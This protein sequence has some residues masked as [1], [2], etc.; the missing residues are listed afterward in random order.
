MAG[1]SRTAATVQTI[2]IAFALLGLVGCGGGAGGGG[3]EANPVAASSGDSA[4]SAAVDPYIVGAV[5]EEISAD[6][7]TVLQ[8]QST[9][10]DE[11]GRFE[12]PEPLTPGSIVQ[13]KS[14]ARGLHVGTPF[15][16]LL[17]RKVGGADPGSGV[18]H[19][20][21]QAW[22]DAKSQDFHGTSTL[23]CSTCHDLA[24]DCKQC[25]FGW[26]GQKAPPASVWSHDD[27]SH[28]D[29]ALVDGMTVCNNCHERGR[30]YGNGPTACHDCHVSANHPGGQAF[31]TKGSVEFHGDAYHADSD[32]CASCH[33]VDFSGG[34]GGLDCAGCHFGAT[35]AREPSASSWS[36]G[37]VPHND[38]ILADAGRVCNSCHY[39]N[40]AYGTGPDPCH[41]CHTDASHPNGQDWLDSSVAGYHGDEAAADVESCAP[42]HGA[43]FRGGASG[44]DCHTCH[45]GPAGAVEP[46]T[47]DGQ[48]AVEVRVAAGSDGAEE[49]PSGL[50]MLTST[51]LDLTTDR[52]DQTVGVRFYCVDVPN[53]ASI[54]TAY[55][56]FQV[57]ETGSGAA[58]FT[59]RGEAADYAAPFTAATY[60][61]SSRLTTAAA[62]SWSPEPWTKAG[63]AGARQRTPEL[64]PIIQEIL[65]RPGWAEGNSLVILVTGTGDRV[66]ESHNGEATAAALLHIENNI[67]HGAIPHSAQ[68]MTDAAAV[69][70]ACHDQRRLYGNGPAACHDCHLGSDHP[71]GPDF[72]DVTSAE[73]HGQDFYADNDA[74]AACHGSDF[75]GGSSAVDC[76]NC[77][78][79]P[80]GAKT[81]PGSS[82]IHAEQPHDDPAL[83]DAAAVCN[84]CHDQLRA[85]GLGPEACHDCHGTSTHAVP[86]TRHESTS[87][88]P[89]D[90]AVCHGVDLKGDQCPACVTCHTAGSPIALTNCTS[91]HDNPPSGSAE[92]NR[93]G[94]HDVHVPLVAGS[95]DA[96]HEGAGTQAGSHFDQ[97][98]DVSMSSAYD[99]QGGTAAYHPSGRTCSNVSCHGGETAPSWQNGSID[100]NRR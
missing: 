86:Y 14:Y 87:N 69:C 33:G 89:D 76:D 73:F 4:Q 40:R 47:A 11:S 81:P 7:R 26:D 93:R 42:C 56:Q 60:G 17:K 32:G 43:D 96:C 46:P 77:H 50:I 71:S 21:G 70:N 19:V 3:G 39:L 80:T 100:V 16:G 5:F 28:L 90:C 83:S 10:S 30:L 20:R 97:T 65:D 38:Q 44:V 94:S 53:G 63:D 54:V 75:S 85:Y 62:V 8:P 6:G 29:P 74:C 82:W 92:P 78:F 12:F 58:S 36:H 59:I 24:A 66:A 18:E 52:V 25:H 13:M 91:C 37:T 57:D 79:G 27:P 99:A 68:V 51:D 15:A 1:K 9:A 34:T 55:V 72:L 41:D 2:L 31:L 64:G 88:L 95:C 98:V 49:T 48:F 23:D 22:L 45:F 84:T 61:I 67:T 35:G